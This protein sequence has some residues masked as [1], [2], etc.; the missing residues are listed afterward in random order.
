MKRALPVIMLLVLAGAPFLPGLK[1]GFTNW[2]DNL[3]LTGNSLV[4]ELSFENAGAIFSRSFVGTYIPLTVFSYALE[5]KAFGL[6]PFVYH[7]DN[8]LL[9]LLNVLLVFWLFSLLG[10][11]PATAFLAALLWAV[12]P[13]RVESVVWV[14]ERKDV[15]YGFFL[16]SSL[17]A[18]IKWKRSER[19]RF[20]LLSLG[21]FF[22]S[23]LAK[24]AAVVLPL[25]LL[26][27]DYFCLVPEIRWRDLFN[28]AAFLA[29]SAV[30]AVIG[31]FSQAGGDFGARD[32]Q[33]R[34]L[35]K[36]FIIC[37]NVLFY[38]HKTAWPWD[39]SIYYPYPK[40]Q[41]GWLPWAYLVSPLLLAGLIWAVWLAAKKWGRE[42][43]FPAVFFLLALLPVLQI[44]TMMGGAVVAERY[45][46]IPSI[47]LFLMLGMAAGRLWHKNGRSLRILIICASGLAYLLQGYLTWNRTHVWQD[48]ATLWSSLIDHRPDLLFAYKKRSQ[49]YWESN[50]ID[51]ALADYDQIIRLDP[52]NL[53]FRYQRALANGRLGRLDLAVSDLDVVI[54]GEPERA[55]AYFNRGYAYKLSGRQDQALADFSRA[56][57]IDP[58]ILNAYMNRAE[59]YVLQGKY[60]KA[61]DDYDAALKIS[62]AYGRIYWKKGE[63]LNA[64]GQGKLAQIEF[65]KAAELGYYN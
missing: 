34:L 57:E 56:L 51:Q 14:T 52:G 63:V 40:N 61:L 43:L 10:Q 37:H 45:S 48:S 2:D 18:Y 6:N 5:F 55:E 3:I 28:K 59:I 60:K 32:E 54:A 11:K 39:L 26:A 65:G 9:H 47:P 53:Q 36:P 49:A 50:R 29:G 21:L 38:I 58:G 44:K 15:L 35:D 25:L 64:L 27:L 42:L 24:G 8:L 23:C 31:I 19:N 22:L 1:A 4:K 7:L 30:F 17:I 20:Y 16:L 62:P 12:N 13:L 33:W 41:T 46:Y